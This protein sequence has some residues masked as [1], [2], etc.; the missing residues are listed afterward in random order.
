M[1]ARDDFFGF[2]GR[3]GDDFSDDPDDPFGLG[4]AA[5]VGSRKLRIHI[6]ASAPVVRLGEASGRA[7][8]ER[9]LVRAV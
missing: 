9:V 3:A 8:L 4:E 7:R 1:S 2:G 5:G 6:K